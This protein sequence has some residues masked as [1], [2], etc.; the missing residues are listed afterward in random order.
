MVATKSTV[1]EVGPT[2]F[3]PVKPE[4]QADEDGVSEEDQEHQLYVRAEDAMNW[5][6]E[7]DYAE[8]PFYGYG[9]CVGGIFHHK[10]RE[11]AQ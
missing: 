6:I 11:V 7:S 2:W 9:V 1:E 4:D 10:R 3:L 5:C 8:G